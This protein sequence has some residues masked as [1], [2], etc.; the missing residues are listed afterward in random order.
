MKIAYYITSHGFGHALRSSVICNNFSPNV[1]LV[2]RTNVPESFFKKEVLRPFSYEPA[3]FDC[4]CI[5]TDGVTVDIGKTIETYSEIARKNEAL[6]ASEAQWCI[7]NRVDRIVSDITPFAF[8]IA[9]AAAIPSVAATNFTWWDIYEEYCALYP[10]FLPY[11]EKIKRQY[12]RASLLLEM[13]PA[14]PMEYFLKRKRIAPVGRVGRAIPE[15]I[16]SRYGIPNEKKIGLIYAGNFGMDAIHWKDLRRFKEWEFLGLYPLKG[17]PSNFHCVSPLDFRYQ[18]CIASV[19]CM[20]G[21]IGYG[22]YAECVINGPPI[23]YLPRED[24]AEYPVLD[25][26]IRRWGGGYFLQPDYFY[27]LKWD[28]ALHAISES[29]RPLPVLS[30]GAKMCAVEIEKVFAA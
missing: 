12:A 1:E 7:D 24:F 29:G 15:A 28:E 30:S 4:G 25:R 9:F 22:L 16:K 19:D 14:M 11:L 21:K 6:L 10:A 18:D 5:Q 23:L 2:F 8:E 3:R 13:E 26:A 17:A 27:G 20:I